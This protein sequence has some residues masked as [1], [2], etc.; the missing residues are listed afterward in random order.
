MDPL[1]P[2]IRTL[3]IGFTALSG[4]TGGLSLTFLGKFILLEK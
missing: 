2:H 4:T 3:N 1:D